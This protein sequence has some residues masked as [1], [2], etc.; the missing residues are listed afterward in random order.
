M[1]RRGLN[2]YFSHVLTLQVFLVAFNLF[3]KIAFVLFTD[4]E[5][6]TVAEKT[7]NKIYNK[8]IRV[9]GSFFWPRDI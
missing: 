2:Y 5:V 9:Q 3:K 7:I 4:P 6:R 8:A 1:S